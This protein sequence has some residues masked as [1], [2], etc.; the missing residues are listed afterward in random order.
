MLVL[1]CSYFKDTN[2]H[3]AGHEMVSDCRYLEVVWLQLNLNNILPNIELM[4]DQNALRGSASHSLTAK[5]D[6]FSPVTAKNENNQIELCS[7]V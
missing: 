7:L 2:L 1:M 5:T 4:I 3:S 6:P